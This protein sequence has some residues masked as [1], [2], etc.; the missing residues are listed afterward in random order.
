[1]HFKVQEV[2]RFLSLPSNAITQEASSRQ[3]MPKHELGNRP[4]RDFF[5]VVA[6][7]IIVLL[8]TLSLL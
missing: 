4:S 1:M 6:V 5:V 7:I 2:V 8:L 3:S